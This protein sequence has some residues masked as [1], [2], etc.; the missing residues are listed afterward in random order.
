[1]SRAE[2]T[3]HAT[4]NCRSLT[5]GSKCYSMRLLPTIVT[6]PADLHLLVPVLIDEVT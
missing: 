1:M 2:M 5:F 4:L 6:L 3:A